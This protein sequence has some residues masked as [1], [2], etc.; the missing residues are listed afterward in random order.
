MVQS[1]RHQGSIFYSN[2]TSGAGE[3]AGYLQYN[4]ND[5]WF[6]IGVNSA[7]RLRV[8]SNGRV[9]IGTTVLGYGDADDLTIANA[10]NAGMTIRAGAANYGS[11]F[12]S[13]ATS[14][15]GQYDAF[16][17]YGHSAQSLSIGAAS[18]TKLNIYANGHVNTQG[19]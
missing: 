6:R 5:N 2:A 19:K 10:S 18:A 15:D 12:F 11:I 1:A 14:G 8:D 4:H 3:Y 16:I 7:E 17:Q 13:D 9:L